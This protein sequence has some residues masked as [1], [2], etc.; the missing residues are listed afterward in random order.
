MAQISKKSP[1]RPFPKGVSGNPGGR[2]KKLTTA[3]K[4]LVGE[5]GKKLVEGLYILA[6]G[7]T[8]DVKRV[9]GKVL[10]PGV[11]DRREC[12]EELLDR[13]FGRPVQAHELSGPDGSP[14]PLADVTDEALAQRADRLAAQLRGKK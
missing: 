8:K 9:F 11:R 12:I 1:G 2:P 7:S 3:V 10:K 5:D 14:I 4:A 13:G 6:F